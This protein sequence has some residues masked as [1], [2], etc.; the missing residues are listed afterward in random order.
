MKI[1]KKLTYIIAIVATFFFLS[2]TTTHAIEYFSIGGRPANPD[3]DIPNSVSWFIYNLDLGES[4]EDELV[5][6]NTFDEDLDLLV[7][8]ADGLKSSSGGFAVRQY[9]EPKEQVGSWVK[10][11]PDPI[12]ETFETLFE[13]YDKNILQICKLDLEDD[14]IL[15]E[16]DIEESFEQEE[17][18][19]LE[20]WCEGEEEVRINVE[21]KGKESIRFVFSVPLTASVG[22]HTG[23]IMIQKVDTEQT[24]TEQGIVLTTRVGVRIYQTVPGEIIKNLKLTNFSLQKLYKEPNFKRLYDKEIKPEEILVSTELENL[25]NVSVDFSEVITITQEFPKKNT[26]TIEDRKFQVLRDDTFTSNYSWFPPRFGKY[27]I[28]NSITY[29][30]ANDEEKTINSDTLTIWLIPWRE[31]IVAASLLAVILIIFFTIKIIRNKKYSGKGWGEYVV[32]VGETLEDLANRFDVD[33]KVLAKT[34]KIKP[35]YI[36]KPGQTI[37]VP[38]KE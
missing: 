36:L 30:D 19:Q 31:L 34:N 6:I 24:G 23:G 2:L 21:S 38:K 7:Y 28:Q 18:E 5:V 35:P 16:A 15:Q 25:G 32:Q 12:P 33:W 26:E 13:E 1:R 27:L 3:P 29:T 9:V 4:K 22:E 10:F 11:Y 17:I 8:A 20:E 37:L 14:E